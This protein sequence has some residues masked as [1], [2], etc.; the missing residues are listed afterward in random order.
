MRL[1]KDN[2]FAMLCYFLLYGKVVQFYIQTHKYSFSYFFHYSL[3]QDIEY[4]SLY[5]TVGPCLSILY[6]KLLQ[7]IGL[8]RVTHSLSD[9]IAM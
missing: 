9:W 1:L 3:L 8:Q 7:S 6:V 5:Y 2:W 4:S